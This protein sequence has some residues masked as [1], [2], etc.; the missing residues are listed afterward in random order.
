M[1]VYQVL[2]R[3]ELHRGS[4]RVA[5]VHDVSEVLQQQQESDASG[6]LEDGVRSRRHHLQESVRTAAEVVQTRE[7]DSAC[8]PRTVYRFV[9]DL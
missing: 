7:V 9:L 2:E 1:Q 4:E 5:A 3:Q 6:D 8:I